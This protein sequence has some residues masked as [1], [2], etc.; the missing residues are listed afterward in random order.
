ML[1]HGRKPLNMDIPS[2]GVD[3]R[4]LIKI[5]MNIGKN[6][7]EPCLSD[8]AFIENKNTSPERYYLSHL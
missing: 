6:D 4:R 1:C 8:I 7:S 3:L 2:C 5:F